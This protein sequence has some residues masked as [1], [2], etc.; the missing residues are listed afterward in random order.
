[1]LN[2]VEASAMAIATTTAMTTKITT[3]A[4]DAHARE[5]SVPRA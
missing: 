4:A 3:A 2:P 1:V 5:G